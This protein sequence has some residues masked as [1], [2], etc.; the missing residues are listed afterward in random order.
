MLRHFEGKMGVH[1]VYCSFDYEDSVFRVSGG[2]MADLLY[3][4]LVYIGNGYDLVRLPKGCLVCDCMF[5]GAILRNPRMLDEFDTSGVISMYG[6]FSFCVFPVEGFSLGR[7]FDTSS[8]G[9]MS[10][11]FECG[12][13]PTFE[14]GRTFDNSDRVKRR[15]VLDRVYSDFLN[16]EKEKGRTAF[17][18]PKYFSL[19]DKFDT[20]KVED[21][22]AMFSGFLMPKNFSLG[23]SFS[24]PGG[25]GVEGMFTDTVFAVGFSFGSE[26][27]LSELV[28]VSSM[29]YDCIFPDGFRFD[30]KISNG[31]NLDMCQMFCGSEFLGSVE[32]G[33][34]FCLDYTYITGMFRNCKFSK[35]FCIKGNFD[36]SKSGNCDDMFSGTNLPDELLEKSSV[37]IVKALRG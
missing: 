29:F 37:E 2:V 7:M 21:M 30:L 34:D 32:F 13:V 14:L 17:P 5:R 28:D 6:M 36:V 20:Y 19:G 15:E 11:M 26:F 12:Y 8:V 16:I 31:K 27:D 25:C 35:G 33:E 10:C 22:T 23:D 9:D 4:V 1:G 3:P 24:V 18:V